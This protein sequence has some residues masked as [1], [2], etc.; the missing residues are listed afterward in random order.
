MKYKGEHKLNRTMTK[1]FRPYGVSKVFIGTQYEI[2][3]KG[4]KLEFTIEVRI[5]DMWFNDFVKQ[6]FGLETNY[7]FVVSLLHE[8]GHIHTYE[9]IP[10]EIVSFDY[11]ETT[12]LTAEINALPALDIEGRKKLVYEYFGLESELAAT[13]WA[14][15][16]INKYPEEV[17]ELAINVQKALMEFY[18]KNGITEDDED[19]E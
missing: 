14:V 8:I 18:I 10:D 16:Y 1:L 19:A 15:R 3:W 6:T 13:K 17:E 2:I 7:P 12:R 9:F 5:E 11:D 4:K